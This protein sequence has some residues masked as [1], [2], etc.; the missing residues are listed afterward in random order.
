MDG[1]VGLDHLELL[2]PDQNLEFLYTD[3]LAFEA[4]QHG[5][6]HFGQKCS[7]QAA[8]LELLSPDRPQGV[9]SGPYRRPGGSVLRLCLV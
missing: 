3:E 6:A 2:A 1:R 5:V 4:V 7:A 9:L 8:L